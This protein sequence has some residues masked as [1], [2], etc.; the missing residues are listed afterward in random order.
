MTK[1]TLMARGAGALLLAGALAACAA[2]GSTTTAPGSGGAV[3][4][5]PDPSRSGVV[6]Y[7]GYSA[8][9]VQEGDTVA[10]VASRVGVPAA[11]L[12]AYNGLRETSTL[13]AGDELVLPPES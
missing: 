3:T 7:D 2:E 4:G 6:V 13:R 5:T 11:D 8:A 10:T 12:A 9:I 1:I